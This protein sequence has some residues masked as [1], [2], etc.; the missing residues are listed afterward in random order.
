LKPQPKSLKLIALLLSVMVMMQGCVVYQQR[1]IGID[2]AVA[3]ESYAKITYKNGEKVR[4][5]RIVSNEGNYYGRKF[6]KLDK[7][8][9]NFL[10]NQE[11]IF[12]IPPQDRTTSTILNISVPLLITVGLIYSITLI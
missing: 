4:Y 10:I 2:E 7:P 9:N 8:S 3:L 5:S 11:R 12:M 6:A 1:S